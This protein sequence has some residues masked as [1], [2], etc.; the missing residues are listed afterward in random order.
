MNQ[1][2]TVFGLPHGEIMHDPMIS[3]Y[4]TLI[5]NHNKDNLS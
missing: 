4:E 2:R 3:S 1:S 5:S